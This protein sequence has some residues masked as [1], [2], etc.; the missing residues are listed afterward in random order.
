MTTTNLYEQAYCCELG[1]GLILRWSTTQDLEQLQK[2]YSFVFRDKADEPLN[3]YIAAWV[4]D[5]MS[6]RHPLTSSDDFALVEDTTK[7]IIVAATCLM[8]QSWNYAGISLPVGRPEIVATLPEYRNRGLVRAVFELIHARSDQRGDFA[9]G[10]TGIHYYYRQFGYEYA[11]DLGG[12]CNLPFTAIPKL[13]EDQTEAYTLRPATPDDIPTVLALYDQERAHMAISADINAEYWR[14]SLDGHSPESGEGWLTFMILDKDQQTVGYTVARRLRA[15][16]ML[17]ING[18]YVKC[19]QSLASVMPSMLRALQK[20]AENTPGWKP[21]SPP[22]A[23]LQFSFGREHP[24]YA[25]LQKAS[26]IQ[27]PPYAWYVRVPNL[28]TFIQHITPV[29]EQR[30]A[31][32]IFAGHTG[33]LRMDFYRGGLRLAFE[34]GK[35]TTV[36][37][38]QRDHNWGQ[39]GQCSFPPQVFLQLLF[40]HR[41]LSELRH[42]FMDVW[43]DDEGRPLLDTLFPPQLAWVTPLD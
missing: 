33:E 12:G 20:H 28:L 17:G 32:S 25:T 2:L 21:D 7:G 43:A 15:G 29:L 31:E 34:N 39:E 13:K 22:A 37:D 16:N 4:R 9:Q 10:I 18:I 5:L 11:L 27:R 36:K 6:N 41:S 26:T 24:V 30:I 42:A 3:Q 1:D 14:Y 38:W 8:K 19:G 35:L 23:Y 40:G